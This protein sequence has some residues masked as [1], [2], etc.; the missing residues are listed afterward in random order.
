[1]F[2]LQ[3]GL[4]G[5]TYLLLEN[6]QK[7]KCQPGKKL[8]LCQYPGFLPVLR[9]RTA[10]LKLNPCTLRFRRLISKAF[11]SCYRFHTPMENLLYPLIALYAPWYRNLTFFGV[12]YTL[13]SSSSESVECQ[14][15]H[16]SPGDFAWKWN[17]STNISL[18]EKVLKGKN[19]HFFKK[20]TVFFKISKFYILHFKTLEKRSS[21]TRNSATKRL[22][23][24]LKAAFLSN[25]LS[26][27]WLKYEPVWRTFFAEFIIIII[28]T[29]SVERVPHSYLIRDD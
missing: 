27:I 14:L 24:P 29:I 18:L 1:M 10:L 7:T 3:L 5:P 13:Y 28:I 26:Y 11:R 8:S 16:P 21:P 22:W 20:L 23:K 19:S 12:W 2:S 6:F 17:C 9:T 25:G 15:P 4:T